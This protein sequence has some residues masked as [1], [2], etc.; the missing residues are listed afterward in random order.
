MKNKKILFV[1]TGN[2]YRSVSAEYALKQHLKRLGHAD[3]E[4]N[5]A[6]T[7]A[8][9][10]R[11]DPTVIQTLEEL[12]VAGLS[13]EQRRVDGSMLAKSDAVIAM[14][15]DHL[16]FLSRDLRYDHAML[17]NTL[18]VGENTSVLDT[19]DAVPDY[20][21]NRPALER[22]IRET[23]RYIFEHTPAVFERLAHMSVSA[24]TPPRDSAPPV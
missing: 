10:Q 23:I 6:G 8:A 4:V 18:A 13:H 3:W 9:P 11:I 19:P 22:T 1:C 12:G 20:R 17:F 15:R 14:A 21:T 5:S 16:D 24:T 7:H 2:I